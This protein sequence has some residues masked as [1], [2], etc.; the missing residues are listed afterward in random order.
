MSREINIGLH[1]KQTIA[2]ESEATE[3]LYGGAKGGGKSHLF[4]VAAILWA[5]QIPG[6]QV[7]IFRRTSPDLW[8]NHM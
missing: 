3:V 6:L 7:Y 5:S 1:Y 2:Y 8:K 4:R